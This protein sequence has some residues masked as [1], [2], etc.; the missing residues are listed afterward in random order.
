MP[1]KFLFKEQ[2]THDFFSEKNF[3]NNNGTYFVRLINGTVPNK[4]PVGYCFCK[5]HKGYLSNSLL[6]E[7]E[8]LSKG[9]VYLKKNEAHNLWKERERK[10]QDKKRRKEERALQGKSID[11]EDV[12]SKIATSVFGEHDISKPIDYEVVEEKENRI[13]DV[14]DKFIESKDY[15]YENIE[16]IKS[17]I[18]NIFDSIFEEGEE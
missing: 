10:K 6:K 2:K 11:V 15:T 16:K 4:Q 14:I 7:H 1:T 17:E 12:V 8:C 5:A 3:A 13:T 18:C 9:C